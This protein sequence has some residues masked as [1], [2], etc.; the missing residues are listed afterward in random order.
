MTAVEIE[1]KIA[2]LIEYPVHPD[3]P[4]EAWRGFIYMAVPAAETFGIPLTAELVLLFANCML[5]AERFRKG[6]V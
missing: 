1:E 5:N 3:V 6:A 4:R 2:E